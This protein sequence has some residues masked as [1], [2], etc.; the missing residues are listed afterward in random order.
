MALLATAAQVRREQA[1]AGVPLGAFLAL[2]IPNL[3]LLLD[4]WAKI[5]FLLQ[6]KILR[7]ATRAAAKFIAQIV[8][9][10]LLAL[11]N[12]ATD[13]RRTRW[14][15]MRIAVRAIKRNRRGHIGHRIRLPS[16]SELQTLESLDRARRRTF[17]PAGWSDRYYWPIHFHHGHRLVPRRARPAISR[18]GPGRVAATFSSRRVVGRPFLSGPLKE[19][20]PAALLVAAS[21]V[22]RELAAELSRPQIDIGE[23]ADFTD[24]EL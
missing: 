4:R 15:A 11:D 7:K 17:R 23:G 14:L 19:Y 12:S 9:E 16:R 24:V 3:H 8:R 6:R 5:P 1:R 20:G 10:R 2:E 13:T 18:Y 21:T 22:N